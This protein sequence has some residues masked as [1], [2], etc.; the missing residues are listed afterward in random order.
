M[1][2]PYT[3]LRLLAIMLASTL[4]LAGCDAL[5]VRTEPAAISAAEHAWARGDFAQ[6]ADLFLE[7]AASQRSQRDALHLRAAEA[8][9]EEGD[10][11]RAARVLVDVSSRRLDSDALQRLGLLQAEIALDRQQPQQAMEQ[12]EQLPGQLAPRYRA[13]LLELRARANEADGNRFAAAAARAELGPLLPE[14][15]RPANQRQIQLLLEPLDD[16][17]LAFGA[18]SLPADHALYGIAARILISRGLPLPR[19]LPDGNRSDIARGLY[20]NSQKSL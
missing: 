12:L 8:W 10:L 14:A 5:P 11:E 9:R 20:R 7:A 16:Q 3:R 18:A 1:P 17:A 19:P 13:R 2:M 15:E 6:A 4:L